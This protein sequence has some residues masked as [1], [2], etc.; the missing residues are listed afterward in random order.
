M[1]D[2]LIEL[3]VKPRGDD[4]VQRS[5]LGQRNTQAFSHVHRLIQRRCKVKALK[6][7][8][9]RQVRHLQRKSNPGAS[10]PTRSKRSEL[11]MLARHINLRMGRQESLGHKLIRVGPNPR[12][13]VQLPD[14][15]EQASALGNIVAADLAVF[16]GL[17][18]NSYG[19]WWVETKSFLDN[20]LEIDQVLD[21]GLFDPSVFADFGV[22]LLLGTAEC[23]LVVEK[24]GHDPCQGYCGGVGAC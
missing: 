12:V 7:P 13:S 20:G 17:V 2:S 16:I 1:D 15:G 4:D 3:R 14:V 24:C 18:G 8:S 10:P 6:Q 21:I 11:K 22:D 9:R 19:A 5:C 23:V